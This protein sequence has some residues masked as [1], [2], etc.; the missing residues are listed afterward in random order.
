MH[1]DIKPQ[2]MVVQPDGVRKVMDFGVARL[3]KRATRHTQAGVVVATPEYMAPEQ[4]FG[5]E[6]DARAGLYD[7]R[8]RLARRV[9][10]VT[11]RSGQMPSE[12]M[13]RGEV[14]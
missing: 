6:I 2:N 5:E 3:A 11:G 1:R 13:Q 7:S 14:Y 12:H 4:L 10:R 9:T 8:E